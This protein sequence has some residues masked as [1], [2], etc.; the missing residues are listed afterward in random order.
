M[1]MEGDLPMISKGKRRIDNE[2]DDDV[3]TTQGG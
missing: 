3:P 2:D 1:L